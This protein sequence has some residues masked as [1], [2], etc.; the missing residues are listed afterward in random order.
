MSLSCDT[1]SKVALTP[2]SD[3]MS[4]QLLWQGILDDNRIEMV[5]QVKCLDFPCGIV[6][7]KVPIWSSAT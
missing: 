1:L 7:H 3:K 2:F 4:S 6:L 5:S